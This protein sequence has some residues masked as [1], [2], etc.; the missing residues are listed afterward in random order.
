VKPIEERGGHLGVAEDLTPFGKAA[1]GGE[2]HRAALIARIDEPEE[3]IAA[4]AM[5]VR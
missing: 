2:D 5:V 3:Q 1:I 4:I